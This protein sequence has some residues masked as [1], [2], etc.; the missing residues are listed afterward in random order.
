MTERRDP[1]QTPGIAVTEGGPGHDFTLPAALYSDAVGF[2]REAIKAANEEGWEALIREERFST[3]AI[4][5]VFSGLEASL[6]QAAFG[7]AEAHREALQQITL[8][9]LT[10]QETTIDD[11]GRVQRRTRYWPFESRTQ[12]LVRF[13]SGKALDKGTTC[14]FTGRVELRRRVELTVAA[15]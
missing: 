14:P 9:V 10:E 6:N 1:E 11:A 7:H 13:L 4:V 15:M 3:A 5:S 2:L 8:D 12:F